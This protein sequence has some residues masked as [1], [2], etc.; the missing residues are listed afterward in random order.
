MLSIERYAYSNKWRKVHPGE[1][2]ALAVGTLVLALNAGCLWTSLAILALTAWLLVAVAGVPLRFYLRL[3]VI[4][5]AFL[6]AGVIALVIT[7]TWEGSREML[8]SVSIGSLTVGIAGQDVVR[9]GRLL[10]RVLSGVSCLYF[11]AL[12]TPVTEIM[13]VFRRVGIPSLFL[14][15]MALVYR[16]TFVLWETAAS[17]YVSQA[18]RLGYSSWCRSLSSLGQLVANLFLKSFQRSQMLNAALL[19]RGFDGEFR[20][21]EPAYCFS[22]R[23]ILLI[24]LWLVFLVVLDRYGGG[25]GFGG[26]FGRP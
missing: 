13:R 19:A 24:V 14:E 18:S 6:A 8:Y 20:V 17:M 10:L 12:T 1:K 4:P 15:L 16:F 26:Y 11:L 22:K 5:L 23:R 3:L 21:L 25:E 9:A 2:V 7:V